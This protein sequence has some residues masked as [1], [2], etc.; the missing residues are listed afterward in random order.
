VPRLLPI[1]LLIGF[2]AGCASAPPRV[3]DLVS[4]DALRGVLPDSVGAYGAAADEVYRGYFADS[5]GA[6]A[7]VTVARTYQN[8]AALMSLNVSSMD[9]PDRYRAVIEA[10]G[11]RVVPDSIM[12]ADAA[13]SAAQAAGWRLYAV[14]Y[15]WV[16]LNEDGRAV[17]AKS[18]FS[19]TAR[20]ALGVVDLAALA[21]LAE[22]PTAVDASFVRS[23][24][25]APAPA[26]ASGGAEAGRARSPGR[27][28]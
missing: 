26:P 14:Q 10:G 7:L 8:G 19:A 25:P 11:G 28:A 16:L 23:M 2:V 21:A 9:R 3:A 13:L 6:L 1:L 18:L 5:T 17:E 22:E 12:Q 4:A 24:P 20:T 27:A 15:G